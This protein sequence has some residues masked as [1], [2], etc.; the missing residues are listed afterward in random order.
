MGLIKCVQKPSISSVLIVAYVLHSLG[1]GMGGRSEVVLFV[2][3]RIFHR[4]SRPVL[5]TSYWSKSGCRC[6]KASQAL[7]IGLKWKGKHGR[8]SGVGVEAWESHP[9]L[10][11]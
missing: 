5:A 7:Y 9:S 11:T 6:W 8:C 10:G 1:A 4:M 3:L 2:F